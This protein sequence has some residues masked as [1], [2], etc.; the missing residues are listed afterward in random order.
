MIYD[1]ES[2]QNYYYQL[3]LRKKEK[4]T[5]AKATQ[6][7]YIINH[8]WGHWRKEYI[9]SLSENQKINYE[10]DNH[11]SISVKDIVLVEKTRNPDQHGRW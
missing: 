8:F 9:I 1:G 7:Q 3:V 6:K 2:I 11:P 5:M 4:L 10:N